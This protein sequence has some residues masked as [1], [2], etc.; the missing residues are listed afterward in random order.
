VPVIS[1][2]L[3]RRPPI[4]RLSSSGAVLLRNS[5]T[6]GEDPVLSVTATAG[7]GERF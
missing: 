2:L 6:E 7:N 4:T 5:G 3:K 1:R